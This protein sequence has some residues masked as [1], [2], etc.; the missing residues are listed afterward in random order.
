[1]SQHRKTRKTKSEK[2]ASLFEPEREHDM[3]DFGRQ[4][5]DGITAENEIQV[6]KAPKKKT[7]ESAPLRSQNEANEKYKG[8][9]VSRS[10]YSAEGDLDFMDEEDLE[11]A[12][13]IKEELDQYNEYMDRNTE[14]RVPSDDENQGIQEHLDG[15]DDADVVDHIQAQ[16]RKEKQKAHSV[17]NQ[18]V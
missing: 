6:F 14:V 18:K 8:V 2:I 13:T 17:F 7:K 12:R 5:D 3:E 1:M 16:R 10:D 4:D 15:L 11:H 9:K